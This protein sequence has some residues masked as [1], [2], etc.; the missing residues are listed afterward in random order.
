MRRTQGVRVLVGIKLRNTA[1]AVDAAVVEELVQAIVPGI[2]VPDS[3]RVCLLRGLELL[4]RR[5]KVT[6]AWP[7]GSRIWRY[8]FTRA[9]SI[10]TI[11]RRYWLSLL[12]T[13]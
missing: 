6:Y 11:E 8:G 10:E 9:T 1:V 12:D 3:T 2:Q 5:L 4:W 7:N 13:Y